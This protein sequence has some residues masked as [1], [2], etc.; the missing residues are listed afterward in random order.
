[1]IF[2][3]I[4]IKRLKSKYF[5]EKFDKFKVPIM[6]H[7]CIEEADIETTHGKGNV[8]TTITH[9]H[10]IYV[11]EHL[12]GKHIIGCAKI[13]PNCSHPSGKTST[14]S[15]NK[16]F[17]PKNNLETDVLEEK[18]EFKAKNSILERIDENNFK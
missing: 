5:F 9:H 13:N 18:V 10:D 8:Y 11:P 4:Y 16:F 6:D 2:L 7:Y 12:K 3:K 14:L 15:N 17:V 1:M